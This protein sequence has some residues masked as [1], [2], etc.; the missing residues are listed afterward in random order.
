MNETAIFACALGLGFVAGLRS[1]L[2]PAAVAW[3]AHLGWLDLN[4]GPVAF[5]GSKGALVI[6]SLFA[7]GELIADKLPRGP[8]RTAAAPLLV[9][10]I[11]GGV[12]GACVF[13]SAKHSLGVGAILGAIGAVL[14]AFAGYETRKRLVARLHISDIFIALPEDLI[15][16]GLALL[17]LAGR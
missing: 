3:A 5:I 8:K 15:A 13:V 11:T 6:L 16:I 9:R 4:A 17:C 1:M 7:I 2:A 14:G 10:M 12:C